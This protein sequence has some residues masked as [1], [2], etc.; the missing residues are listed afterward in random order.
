MGH[1]LNTHQ[2]SVQSVLDSADISNKRK[3]K[4]VTLPEAVSDDTELRNLQD[5]LHKIQ[6]QSWP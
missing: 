4:R 5:S 3:R 1:I 6:L 2:V